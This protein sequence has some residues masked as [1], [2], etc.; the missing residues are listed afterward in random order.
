LEPLQNKWLASC[1][2]A[3]PDDQR[4]AQKSE[5]PQELA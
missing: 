4:F 3:R 5:R 2:E 1:R